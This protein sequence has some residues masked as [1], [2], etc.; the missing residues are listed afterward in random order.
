MLALGDS[1]PPSRFR[2]FL[3]GIAGCGR[4]DITGDLLLLLLLL[5]HWASAEFFFIFDQL[6]GVLSGVLGVIL[7]FEILVLS[8]CRHGGNAWFVFLCGFGSCRIHLFILFCRN[9]NCN[10][11]VV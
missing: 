7:F 3:S 1:G 2:P 5:L 10:N 4:V 6:V 8:V 9:H 11:S